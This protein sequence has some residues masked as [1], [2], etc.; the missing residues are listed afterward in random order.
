MSSRTKDAYPLS[1]MQ[2]GMLF[3][4]VSGPAS[5]VYVQQL[6]C[7]LRGAIEVERFEHAWEELF[8]RHAV[9]RTA[10]AWHGLPEPLQVVGERVRVPLEVLDWREEPNDLDALCVAERI[11]GF[12]LSRAPLTRLRLVRLS[13]DEWQLVWTWHHA[14][15]DAWSVPILMEELFATYD[16]LQLEPVRPYKDF[17][18]WQRGRAR[19]DAE[20]FWRRYLEGFVEPTP[21]AIEHDT[22]DSGYGLELLEVPEAEVDALR[23]AARRSRLTLNTFVQAAWALLL[24][25]YSGRDEV[26]FGTAVAGRPP[27]LAGV[28]KMVGLLI[29]TLPVRM[30]I[31]PQ[32]P[33]GEWLEEVQHRQAETRRHEQTPLADVQAWTSVPRG[34]PLFESLLVFENVPLDVDRFQRGP[35]VLEGFDF[36]ERA[37]FPLTVMMEVRAK[38]KLGVGWDRARFDRDSMRRLL[39]HLRMLLQEMAVSSER[40]IGELDCLT[41]AERQQ[42]VGEWS[43]GPHANVATTDLSIARLFEA[44]VER[45]PDAPAAT[46]GGS[47]A[48]VTL[49]YRELNARANRVARG[50]QAQGVQLGDRVAV[51]MDASLERLAAIL[52][53]LKA[54]AAYVP[55]DPSVPAARLSD[56]VA[57]SGARLLLDATWTLPEGGDDSNLDTAPDADALAYIIYTSGSTGVPKGVAVTHR[58][59]HH[60][61]RAQIDAFQIDAQSRVLQFASLS[62]DASVSEIFTALLAGAR[63][64]LAPRRVLL[65][66]RELMQLLERWAISVV[67][68]PPSV[69]SRLPLAEWRSLKT[70]VSAGEACSAELVQRWARGRRFLNAYGPTEVTVCATL[71]VVRSAEVRSDEAEPSI[72]RAM[73]DARVYVLDSQLR[74]VPIGVAG[75]LYVGGPGVALGYW[76]RPD[77]TAASFISDPFSNGA[78]SRLYR[79]G[80]L[81]RFRSDGNLE[82]LGRRDAQVKVRGF[83]VEP[84]E[85]ETL[86]RRDSS[87]AEAAVAVTADG[88]EQR[89][90]AYVV[91]RR[92]ANAE[93]WPSIAEYFVYDELAYHAMTTD[94]RR[95][96]SYRQAFAKTVRDKVVVEVGTGPEALLS[97]FCIEAGARKV[98]ALELLPD[99]YRKAAARVRELGLDDRIEVILGDATK[100]EL[101]EQAD[102]C[103]SEIVGAIGG[104]EGAAA[105]MNGVRRL[106]RDDAAIVPLR[107]TTL[108]APV[109][110]PEALLEEL[111]F[112]DLPARYVERIF[113]EVG[114]P[115]DL[116]LCI[117]GLNRSHLLARPRVFEDLDYR[118]AVDPEVRHEARFEIERDGRV[119]G[120]LVWLTLET[121]GEKIDILE[122]EHCW[123]PVFFPL[124]DART[125]VRKDDIVDARSGAVLTAGAPHPDYFVEGTLHRA[126]REPLPFRHDAPRHGRELGATPFYARM[127][128]DGSV[129][130][131][132]TKPA[133]FDAVALKQR[134]R[135]RLPEHMI[136]DAFVTLEQLPLLPSGKLDR[137]GLPEAS[138]SQR[139]SVSPR[140]V[141]P[142]SK[143]E[144]V[145]AGIWRQLLGLGEDVGLDTNFFD[146]GGHSL[147]LLRVQD[148]L[149]EEAGVEL[150]VAELFQYPTV[151]SLAQRL[152]VQ[153]VVDDLV[154]DDRGQLRASARQQALGRM[155]NRRQAR[156]AGDEPQ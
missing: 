34:T 76:N 10:F 135:E 2:Q 110:L 106:L 43:R 151:E 44:Q 89:I 47:G 98:Y 125:E 81:V 77:L 105:I 6:S 46:F 90:V 85:I 13:H 39:G 41:P 136:P 115:F 86:L 68:L 152:G 32:R 18:A 119:D 9:L 153:G 94:E 8:R 131:T 65:P 92:S 103:V 154:V 24:S 104:S 143:T 96:E 121:G 139:T 74:P 4:S 30:R 28:E 144:K 51:C 31:D 93:W 101:P 108:Y 33:L 70:L 133:T 71:A 150:S 118:A 35:L 122:H 137:R 1:P 56:T 142:R 99:S 21:L 7:R 66:S 20:S 126:G 17:V 97:R 60:L 88:G 123:L 15:L 124:F 116:R 14:I 79:T 148:L 37:N 107:S 156:S 29:N 36:V 95:N 62:F 49:T 45:T 52:G 69:L 19:G 75:E 59:L 72:G 117:K 63:L 22:G 109:E 141:P 80:D 102:V 38:S 42:L 12:D 147:L 112:G 145:V 83:R 113:A 57:D 127:F 67:T 54:G 61:V 25:R 146:H 84:G 23:D 53:I 138:A 26:L 87:V 16:G 5:D 130:R 55:V 100:V 120:L 91:P 114:R 155:S 111:A 73:G 140:N 78:G 48:D 149:R 82:F 134:L 128:R 27:E 11:R 58:S 132:A 50:L 64:Y 40:S 129:P 3:H